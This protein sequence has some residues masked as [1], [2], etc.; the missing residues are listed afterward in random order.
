M[1]FEKGQSQFIADMDKQVGQSLDIGV[2]GELLSV[3][4]LDK[5]VAE[6]VYGV[7]GGCKW[8]Y[9]VDR[10]T[11]RILSWR[12][13]SRPEQCRYETHWLGPW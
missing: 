10:D 9:D 1:S 13:V 4:D 7:D 12:F 11:N 2:R 3:R 8:A 6:Y 5:P